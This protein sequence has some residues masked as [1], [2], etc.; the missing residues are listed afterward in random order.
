MVLILIWL[1]DGLED[2]LEETKLLSM[3]IVL[4]LIWLE[5]GLEGNPI[6]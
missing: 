3:S 4:I 5:D 2:G 6:Y 1:E